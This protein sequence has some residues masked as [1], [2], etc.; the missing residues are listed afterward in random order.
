V[1]PQNTLPKVPIKPPRA[2]ILGVGIHALD[3][4][5]A[6]QF[7]DDCIRS[8]TKGYVC[9]AGVHGVMEARRQA[10]F[11]DILD[12]ALLVTSDGMPTV[13]IGR[14][15]KQCQMGRVFGPDFMREVCARSVTSQYTHFLYGGKPAIADELRGKLEQWFPGIRIV[16]TFTPPFRP[17]NRQEETQLISTVA[18]LKPDVIWVGLSTPKQE[19]FMA[20]MIDK[21]SCKLMIGVGAAFDFH[22]GKLKD[23]PQWVKTAGLQ[24]LH[25]LYQDPGRLWKRYLFNN[26]EFLWN[27]ALQMT[28]VRH[29]ELTTDLVTTSDDS[30]RSAADNPALAH[31]PILLTGQNQ[32][33][34]PQ[35]SLV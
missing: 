35:T 24:W 13:W 7:I 11:R 33:E 1:Y 18:N 3:I 10:E 14:L 6:V 9:V 32:R 22:T 20:E 27:V 23:A 2:N 4:G 31:D 28:R 21:L 12:K 5:G 29:Y 26:S 16:G 19:R 30:V 25:R 34:N 15:Q 8:G 17:L